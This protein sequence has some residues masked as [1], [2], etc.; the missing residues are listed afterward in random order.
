MDRFAEKDCRI[1]RQRDELIAGYPALWRGITTD[2]RSSAPG[3]RGWLIYSANYLFRTGGVRW[4]IDPLTLG[5]RLKTSVAEVDTS[6]FGGTDFI[7]LTH[8]HADHLDLELISALRHCP[9]RWVVPASLLEQVAGQAGI[10]RDLIVVPEPLR[11]LEMS[12]LR[13]IPFE[14]SHWEKLAS[15]G[16]KGVPAMGYVV[17][18]Q[19][20]RWL[21]P[22]DTRTYDPTRIPVRGPVDVLFAHLWLGRGCALESSPPLLEA[23]CRFCLDQQP[24]RIVLTHLREFGRDARDF[25]DETHL[26]LVLSGF[27]ELSSGT[28]V[29]PALTGESFPL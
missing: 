12:G 18:F 3:D 11:P 24:R 27:Q 26:P 21:F 25:W 20:R 5:W 23:F 16:L 1:Q 4:A 6:V 22:G 7:L 13:I 29:R 14:G 28:P 2:W 15:G 17:E 8:S 9:I 10:P 19:G